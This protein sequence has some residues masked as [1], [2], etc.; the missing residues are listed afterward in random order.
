MNAEAASRPP[1]GF[2][3][4]GLLV[5][6]AAGSGTAARRLTTGATLRLLASSLGASV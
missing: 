4:T 3:G 1:A 5:A 6:I 2:A